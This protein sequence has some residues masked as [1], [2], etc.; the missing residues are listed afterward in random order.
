M[1]IDHTPAHLTYHGSGWAAAMAACCAA[2][3][4]TIHISALSL[5]P[6][7]QNAAG[8]WPELW[9]AWCAAARRGVAVHIWLPAPMTNAPATRGNFGAGRAITEAGMHVHYVI[10]NQLLHAKQTV[11]DEII[12][13]IGS[14]NFTS[15]AAHFNHEA[16]L[17]ANCPHIGAQIVARLKT[18]A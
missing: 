1:T 16:Y 18:L 10:G 15:A 4:R 5:L 14:G 2:A 9:R 8:H 7:T 12:I 6:P 3:Q 13:W 11:V 17:S